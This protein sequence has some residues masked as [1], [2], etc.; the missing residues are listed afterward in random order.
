MTRD[1]PPIFSRHHKVIGSNL[2]VLPTTRVLERR[3][4][5][6]KGAGDGG[7]VIQ[8]M[9]YLDRPDCELAS[10]AG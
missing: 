8:N 10:R 6:K 3:G 7:N 9:M 2:V 4:S 1:K 5:P